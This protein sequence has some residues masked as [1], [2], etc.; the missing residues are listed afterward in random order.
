MLNSIY[1]KF[2]MIPNEHII[3]ILYSNTYKYKLYNINRKN[4]KIKTQ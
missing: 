4:G 2:N 3:K 1:T